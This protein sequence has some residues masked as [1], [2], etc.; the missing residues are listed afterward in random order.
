MLDVVSP[1]PRDEAGE[2]DDGEGDSALFAATRPAAEQS[3]APSRPAPSRPAPGPRQQPPQPQPQAP[4]PTV[5]VPALRPQTASPSPV[6][7][8]SAPATAPQPAAQPLPAGFEPPADADLGARLEAF[9]DWVVSATQSRGAVITDA[10]GLVVV[11]R[12]ADSVDPALA[13]CVDLMLDRAN[14]VVQGE[15]D[16]YVALQHNDLHFVTLWTPTEYGRFYGVLIGETA[17]PREFIALAGQG[18]RALFA[19]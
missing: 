16:G 4:A 10:H 7:R 2:E 12:Q 15:F 17:P 11:E 3:A 19:N 14:D 6:P 8:P 18:F 5:R 9:L 1:A 13:A